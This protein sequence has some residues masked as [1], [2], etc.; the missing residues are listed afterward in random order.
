MARAQLRRYQVKPGQMEAFINAWRH[1]AVPVRALYGFEVLAS[2]ASEDEAEFGWVVSYTGEGAFE[3]AEKAYY[4]SP[5]R[6]A[7][8]EDPASYLDKVET[9]M[10]EPVAPGS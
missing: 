2:W 9:R 10:I 7:M 5:E 6:A 3:D 8:S 1:N 4:A